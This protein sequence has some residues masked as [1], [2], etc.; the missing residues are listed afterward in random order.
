[1]PAPAPL[2]PA[3]PLVPLILRALAKQP[4]RLAQL[5]ECLGGP[6]Q[7]TLRTRLGTTA[8]LGALERHGAG[9]PYTV[10]HRLT[11]VGNDLLAASEVRAAWLEP[12]P[13]LLTP[14]APLPPRARSGPCSA[15]GSRACS[16]PAP[17]SPSPRSTPS[18][19]PSA[20]PPS[21]AVSPRCAPPASSSAP[22]ATSPAPPTR[23]PSAPARPSPIPC[24]LPPRAPPSRPRRL[25][26]PPLDIEAAF[27]LASPVPRLDP[28]LDGTCLLAAHLPGSRR[29]H[30]VRLAVGRGAIVES[31]A[32]LDHHPRHSAIAPAPSLARRPRPPPVRRPPRRRRPRARRRPPPPSP[33][34]PLRLRSALRLRWR[35]TRAPLSPCQQSS[36]QRDIPADPPQDRYRQNSN[37]EIKHPAICRPKASPASLSLA[38]TPRGLR[39]LRLCPHN[40]SAFR[41]G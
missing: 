28:A 1:M 29:L 26:A 27:L 32:Q 19:A 23:S 41:Q 33:R 35:R 10:Q 38:S 34:R 3:M 30:G 20:T 2:R 5:Q 39:P 12:A 16:A 25:R 21:S 11:D 24:R 7:S 4:L 31:V 6:T 15:A 22:P 36:P 40:F 17:P 9:M 37:A 14:S 8:G 13:A 18:S